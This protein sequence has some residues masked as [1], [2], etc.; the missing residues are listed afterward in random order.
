METNLSVLKEREVLRKEQSKQTGRTS[1][2]WQRLVLVELNRH[3]KNIIQERWSA[4]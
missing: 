2:S 4:L 1:Q 3:S